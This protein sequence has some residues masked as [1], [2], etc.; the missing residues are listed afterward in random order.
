MPKLREIV[1]TRLIRAADKLA[2]RQAHERYV[3]TY[4][5]LHI[6]TTLTISLS[7]YQSLYVSEF[8]SNDTDTLSVLFAFTNRA[9]IDITLQLIPTLLYATRSR[10][11]VNYFGQM[12][13]PYN[14]YG[15]MKSMNTLFV[16]PSQLWT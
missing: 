10:K 12:Q 4:A 11:E 2:K 8:I 7:P 15:S 16:T 14:P 3:G 5:A 13:T 1:T 6:N 9:G